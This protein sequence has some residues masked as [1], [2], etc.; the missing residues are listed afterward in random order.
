M[1]TATINT[2]LIFVCWFLLYFDPRLLS[3]SRHNPVL[4]PSHDQMETMDENV[5]RYDSTGMFHWCPS[6][7]IDKVVLV[8]MRVTILYVPV[9]WWGKTWFCSEGWPCSMIQI[10]KGLNKVN[11]ISN[12]DKLVPIE[13]KWRTK[14]AHA[15]K[16]IIIFTY[17]NFAVNYCNYYLTC[18]P[19]YIFLP[20]YV[21]SLFFVLF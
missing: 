13:R 4:I 20:I 8:S 2:N 9:E 12:H 1:L 6:I 3:M 14:M 5:K 10:Y 17:N 11:L 21:H 18:I 16:L 15:L 19:L 7:D